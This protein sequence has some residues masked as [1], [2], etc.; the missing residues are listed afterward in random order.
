MNTIEITFF[1]FE[2]SS[3]ETEHVSCYG[4]V[5]AIDTT[6]HK[7]DYK[8]AILVVTYLNTDEIVTELINTS[9]LIK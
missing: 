6:R 7:H 1:N 8:I 3:V 4:I 9:K 2:T 5:D